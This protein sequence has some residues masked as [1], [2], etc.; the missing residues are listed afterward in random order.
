MNFTNLLIRGV[1]DAEL[2]ISNGKNFEMEKE[3][4]LST[5]RTSI[6]IEEFNTRIDIYYILLECFGMINF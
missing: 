5:F 4:H 1:L 2:E 6:L 3:N